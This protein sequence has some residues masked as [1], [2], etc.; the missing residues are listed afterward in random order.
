MADKL[1]AT[2]K[3]RE[4]KLKQIKLYEGVNIVSNGK[5]LTGTISCT[6]EQLSNFLERGLGE[7]I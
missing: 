5:V 2:T 6:K 3:P 7:V 1:V 4:P